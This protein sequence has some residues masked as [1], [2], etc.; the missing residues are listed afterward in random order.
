MPPRSSVQ[1]RG[2]ISLPKP[3]TYHY[4]NRFCIRTTLTQTLNPNPKL[5]LELHLVEGW[6]RGILQVCLL[7]GPAIKRLT[8]FCFGVS[9][10]WCLEFRVL[11]TLTLG[12]PGKV[13]GDI[14]LDEAVTPYSARYWVQEAIR[15]NWATDNDR[16]A[17]AS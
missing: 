7:A 14:G 2:N 1:Q 4:L 6:L 17:T 13:W 8:A 16:S 10:F 3:K 9:V 12:Q 5:S 15:E 11:L